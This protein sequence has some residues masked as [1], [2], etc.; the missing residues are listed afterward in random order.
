MKAYK[1]LHWTRVIS[2]QDFE[3]HSAR[4]YDMGPDIIAELAA[5]RDVQP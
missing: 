4:A 3:D 1:H 5:M 2:L